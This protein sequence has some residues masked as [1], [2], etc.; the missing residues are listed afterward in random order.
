MIR[1]W[2]R[3]ARLALHL[4]RGLF[5]AGCFFPFQSPVQ[6]RTEIRRWSARLLE[7]LAVRLHMHGSPLDTRPLMFVANHVTWL[8]IFLVD[9]VLPVRFVAKAEVRRWPLVGWLSARCG[10][11]FIHRARR[12]DTARINDVVTHALAAGEVFAV[13]PEGTT[14][15]GSH[16]LK[17][18]ASLLEPALLA[19][20]ALQPVALR[21]ERADGTLCTEAAFDGTRS[22]WDTLMGITSQAAI[23]AHL[24]FLPA[25]ATAGRHRRELAAE[26]RD[27]I[28][29]RL[30]PR[31]R[32]SRTE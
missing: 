28:S 24:W 5:I 17:F 27:A 15:D 14:T 18:H 8:D 4:A 22:L 30:S 6:R 13:F 12:H 32:C 10:T 31:A 3:I 25:L 26:A 2:L 9:A 16:L 21:Y 11:A 23:D 29:L 7:V 20:A 1:R 19:G